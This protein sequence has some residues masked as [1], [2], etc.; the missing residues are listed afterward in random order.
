MTMRPT[1]RNNVIN[2]YLALPRKYF[3]HNST[4]PPSTP[5]SQNGTPALYVVS[6]LGTTDTKF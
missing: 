2:I 4:P 5:A 3:R 6:P 1:Q